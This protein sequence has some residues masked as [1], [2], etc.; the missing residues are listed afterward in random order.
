VG[1][2][3]TC[4]GV[5]L[6]LLL[7]D[8]WSRTSAKNIESVSKPSQRLRRF[9]PAAIPNRVIPGTIS[10]SAYSWL[11]PVK[12]ATVLI[13]CGVV[14]MDRVLDCGP[15]KVSVLELKLQPAAGGGELQVR[16]TL[17]YDGCGDN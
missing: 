7:Q 6:L 14:V 5:L 12:E 13:G 10:H 9:F 2:P 3:P 17:P 4:G 15:F 8:G 11:L 1:V 16:E